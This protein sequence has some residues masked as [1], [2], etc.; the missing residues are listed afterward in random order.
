MDILFRSNKAMFL[1][2]PLHKSLSEASFCWPHQGPAGDSHGMTCFAK[3]QKL[4]SCW[5]E[6]HSLL[7]D[8]MKKLHLDLSSFCLSG[9][10]GWREDEAAAGGCELTPQTGLRGKA[11]GGES[12]DEH[13]LSLRLIGGLKHTSFG[14]GSS[15]DSYFQ[16][17]A[18]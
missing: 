10:L 3:V 13:G 7:G 15:S 11:W 2:L 4:T 8:L 12:L 5:P 18:V 14:S 6:V 1:S 17:T 9:C 16:V